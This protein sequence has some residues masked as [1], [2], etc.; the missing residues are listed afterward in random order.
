MGEI[1]STL[2]L[3]LERTKHLSLSDEEK[4]QHRQDEFSQRVKGII[5]KYHDKLIKQDRIKEVLIS[6]QHEY[7]IDYK[8]LILADTLDRIRLDKDNGALFDLL[9]SGCDIE[10]TTLRTL[11]EDYRRRLTAVAQDILTNAK[12]ELAESYNIS[13]TA[14]V[15]NIE[16]DATLKAE[17]AKLYS[18]FT[19][20]L[21]HAKDTLIKTC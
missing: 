11:C 21:Q 5:Q 7:G 8:E 2:E 16:K 12:K 15:P 20:D 9:E 6:L 4:Q 19:N 1:K 18:R 10:T 17:I 14:I 3:A 13:G